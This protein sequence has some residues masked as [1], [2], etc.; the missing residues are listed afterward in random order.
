VALLLFATPQTT[1]GK[2]LATPPAVNV[3]LISYS[4]YLWHQP[5]FAFARLTAAR[6]PSLWV[7][8]GL[9]AATFP[10]GY[11]SWRFIERP[12][13]DRKRFTRGQIFGIAGVVSAVF[14]GLGVLII[15]TDGL[16]DRYPRAD[17]AL[18]LLDVDEAGRYVGTRFNELDQDF[19]TGARGTKL[20][21]V[22]DSFA[23]DLV[24]MIS[25]NQY[26]AH[27]QIRTFTILTE[28]Q[29][30]LRVKD[31]VVCRK[32]SVL[33]PVLQQRLRMADIIILTSSWK[34]EAAEHLPETIRALKFRPDQKLIVIGSK[35]FSLFRPLNY[36][37]LSHKERLALRA[38]I[39]HLPANDILRREF[40]PRVFVDFS[41][42]VCPGDICPVFTPAEKIIS[43]D[44]SHM[45]RDGARYSGKLLF[46]APVLKALDAAD[47]GI[48]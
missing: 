18:L 8:A 41:P 3:G 43:F 2:L 23:K 47:P 33:S 40:P 9:A 45:T 34:P 13:R 21:I 10:I 11:L 26:L 5:L 24:N 28:C 25:E 1:I 39:A 46:Q 4:V 32:S 12:F 48:K 17:R 36:L 35:K 7:F 14:V 16:I 42:L 15:K 6:P 27:Y 38:R 19:A 22:G 29:I 20:L 37:S 31:S 30:M 44:G